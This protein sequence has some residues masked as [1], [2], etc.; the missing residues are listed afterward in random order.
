MKF[1]THPNGSRRVKIK[2]PNRLAMKVANLA[3]VEAHLCKFTIE[4]PL[5]DQISDVFRHERE[6]VDL[7]VSSKSHVIVF[8]GF[9]SSQNRSSNQQSQCETSRT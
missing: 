1:D 6:E 8:G 4:V 9:I 5:T 3:R 2:I 7:S